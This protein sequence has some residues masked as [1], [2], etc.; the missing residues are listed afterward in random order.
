MYIK[1]VDGKLD[2]FE[3]IEDVNEIINRSMYNVR[4]DVVDGEYIKLISGYGIATSNVVFIKYDGGSSID[5][6]SMNVDIGSYNPL[7][8]DNY[9]FNNIQDA[10]YIS[11][12]FISGVSQERSDAIRY[13][14]N[15]NKSNWTDSL[16][17]YDEY[18]YNRVLSKDTENNEINLIQNNDDNII[19]SKG[20]ESGLIPERPYMVYGNGSVR[21]GVA[22]K[23]GYKNSIFEVERRL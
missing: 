7:S 9:T 14:Y 12:A 2:W 21:T 13:T 22:K 4:N 20:I 23:V 5:I 17:V 19:V 1:T 3:S 18:R 8:T 15:L 10:M 16:Y 11:F 6:I